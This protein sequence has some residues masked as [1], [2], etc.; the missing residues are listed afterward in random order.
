MQTISQ[1]LQAA[2]TRLQA[3]K[4]SLISSRITTPVRMS[5]ATLGFICKFKNNGK[6]T[7][8]FAIQ[9]P[10]IVLSFIKCCSEAKVINANKSKKD[11]GY[12]HKTGSFP[13]VVRFFENYYA[14]QTKLA[15]ATK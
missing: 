6:T 2:K 3:D 15:A 10:C 8:F 1:A 11:L 4:S 9:N 14:E 13:E 5:S 7:W 12:I